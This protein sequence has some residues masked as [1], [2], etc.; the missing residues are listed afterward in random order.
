MET[1]EAL[2]ALDSLAQ[3]SRLDVFRLLVR[4]GPG[5]LPAGEIARNL[6]IP[7]ATL[8]FHLNHLANAGLVASRRAGRSIIYSIQDASVHDLMRFLTQECCD[9]RPE[10]CGFAAEGAEAA[11]CDS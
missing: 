8:S 4:T 7:P 10:L 5:G 2:K 11:C 9:G 6:D 3:Q 1:I